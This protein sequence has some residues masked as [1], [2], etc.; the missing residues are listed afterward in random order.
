LP[1]AFRPLGDAA[2]DAD[3]ANKFQQGVTVDSAWVYAVL[4]DSLGNTRVEGG[5]AV[6]LRS[7]V[8]GTF[9]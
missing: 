6:L 3:N 4:H 2:D 9:L 8:R 1:K 5:G 7:G